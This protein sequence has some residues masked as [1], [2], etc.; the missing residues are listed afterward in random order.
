MGTKL[1]RRVVLTGAA[2]CVALRAMRSDGQV[3]P[4][5]AV[6][7]QSA[8]AQ[9]GRC[10][11]TLWKIRHLRTRQFGSEWKRSEWHH[12]FGIL[13]LGVPSANTRPLLECRPSRSLL[14]KDSFW[15]AAT[16]IERKS[17][18]AKVARLFASCRY[19]TIAGDSRA[20][21]RRAET[22]SF[23]AKRR[24]TDLRRPGAV[25]TNVWNLGTG[26][27]LRAF[28]RAAAN[29]S[30][31]GKLAIDE[32]AALWSLRTGRG[33]EPSPTAARSGLD[34]ASAVC[35]RAGCPA[36]VHLRERG[37]GG[38][39]GA[40]AGLEGPAVVGTFGAGDRGC[41]HGGRQASRYGMREKRTE[42]RRGSTVRIW[43]AESTKELATLRGHDAGVRAVSASANGRR[44]VSGDV[45]GRVIL[46]EV[47][48]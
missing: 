40:R 17:F 18:A 27:V 38:T 47:S 46:W 48:Q 15:S 33:C 35:G 22:R 28:P 14:T 32:G 43:D 11:R 1:T 9:C 25:S 41:L 44:V 20:C 23:C 10:C 42:G 7:L 8:E 39:L 31:D 16:A 2:G 37:T 5:P 13:M 21:F 12:R 6:I 19:A 34:A 4:Q 29:F 45:D 30:R 26:K 24:A 3:K 36:L